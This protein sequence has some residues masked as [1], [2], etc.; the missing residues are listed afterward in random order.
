[1]P[2]VRNPSADGRGFSIDAHSAQAYARDLADV[3]LKETTREVRKYTID[4]SPEDAK[5]LLHHLASWWEAEKSAVDAIKSPFDMMHRDPILRSA[6]IFV[7][8][9]ADPLL[10][11]V[12]N[13]SD[14]VHERA[15]ELLG[16]F[17]KSGI[18][19]LVASPAATV[20]GMNRFKVTDEITGA[21]LDSSS[22]SVRSGTIA[23]RNWFELSKRYKIAQ[24]DRAPLDALIWKVANRTS[25]ELDV[26]IGV[27]ADLIRQRLVKI[28]R[29]QL[30]LLVK[31]LSDLLQETLMPSDLQTAL[32]AAEAEPRVRFRDR[33]NVRWSATRLAYS[34]R[35]LV[36]AR[37]REAS[38][39]LK[40]WRDSS[41]D[42]T[43]PELKRVWARA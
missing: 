43:L 29:E 11:K 19:V 1:V 8:I 35:R 27:L 33:P 2:R 41:M 28:S 30:S 14:A 24:P 10:I 34:V 6:E 12:R 31:A 42:A 22:D 3:S 13:L 37:D 38:D 20:V 7:R 18:N 15:L 4:W 25:P 23:L 36:H 32:L 21:I 16:S 9:L 26:A 40:Q 5:K 17:S 39:V